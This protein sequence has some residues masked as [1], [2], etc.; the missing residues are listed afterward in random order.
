MDS[1]TRNVADIDAAD[2]QALEHV[3]GRSL[4]TSQ[5]VVINVVDIP[6][7]SAVSEKQPPT[8]PTRLPDWCNVYEG[9]TDDEVAD[10]EASIIRSP[11]GR[12]C[13]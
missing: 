13:V 2:R 5:Q 12:D 10:I 8:T 11:G 6:A 3:I 9:L 1:V 7:A 4:S